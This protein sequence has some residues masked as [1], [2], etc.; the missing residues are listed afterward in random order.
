M[1]PCHLFIDK[2]CVG[3]PDLLDVI[4]SN[5]QLVNIRLK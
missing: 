5:N 3:N 4:C 1:K 2:E